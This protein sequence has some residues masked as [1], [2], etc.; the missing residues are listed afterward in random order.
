MGRQKTVFKLRQKKLTETAAARARTMV[1][2][3]CML[4]TCVGGEYVDWM[5]VGCNDCGE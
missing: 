4:K 2:L 3:N 5:D 1:F